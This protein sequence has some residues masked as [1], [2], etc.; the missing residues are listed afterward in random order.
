MRGS[1]Q[2][3]ELR[4]LE[5]RQYQF[6]TQLKDVKKLRK[7]I[8]AAKQNVHRTIEPNMIVEHNITIAKIN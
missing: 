2:E 5:K 7:L 4:K 1:L 6:Y 3:D 8:T